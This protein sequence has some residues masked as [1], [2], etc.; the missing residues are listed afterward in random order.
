MISD[1]E[2]EKD[3]PDELELTDQ[4]LEYWQER[5]EKEREPR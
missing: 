1:L 3:V 5:F 2:I 4:Q